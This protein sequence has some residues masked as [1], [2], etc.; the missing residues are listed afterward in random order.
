MSWLVFAKQHKELLEKRGSGSWLLAMAS[1]LQMDDCS[2]AEARA[3]RIDSTI[4]AG[5]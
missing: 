2:A 4:S 3:D 5:T 1:A